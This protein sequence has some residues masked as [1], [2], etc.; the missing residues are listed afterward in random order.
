MSPERRGAIGAVGA[1]TWRCYAQARVARES[2][3][4]W[5][6]VLTLYRLALS[7]GGTPGRCSCSRAASCR[8]AAPAAR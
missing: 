3:G 1:A 6:S 2:R 7:E 4:G 8:S 5:P